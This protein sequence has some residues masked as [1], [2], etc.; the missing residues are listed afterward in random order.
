MPQYMCMS[1]SEWVQRLRGEWIPEPLFK[2]GDKVKTYDEDKGKWVSGV[3]AVD[4][5]PPHFCKE[6]YCWEYPVIMDRTTG[7]RHLIWFEEKDLQ[8]YN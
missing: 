5:D 6:E 1:S 4:H 8:G 3:I 2:P 7:C